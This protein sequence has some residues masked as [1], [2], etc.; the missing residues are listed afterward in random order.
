MFYS[1]CLYHV[2]CSLCCSV[3]AHT[4]IARTRR[5]AVFITTSWSLHAVALPL[6]ISAH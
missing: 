4:L 3:A 5:S 2:S 6:C 1:F